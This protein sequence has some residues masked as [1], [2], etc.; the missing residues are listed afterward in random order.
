MNE[1]IARLGS[2]MQTADNESGKGGVI[3]L[4]CWCAYFVPIG[5]LSL[6]GRRKAKYEK[7]L[8]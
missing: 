2:L 1:K 7:V 3:A 5:I 6:I 8:H 4:E